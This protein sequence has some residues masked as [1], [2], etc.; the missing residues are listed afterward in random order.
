M[1]NLSIC[2]IN[3]RACLVT[4]AGTRIPEIMKTQVCLSCQELQATVSSEA[5]YVASVAFLKTNGM[6]RPQETGITWTLDEQYGFIM[7]FET[8]SPYTSIVREMTAT[9]F[10]CETP[11]VFC[12]LKNFTQPSICTMVSR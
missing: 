12:G 1:E 3:C 6:W 7:F 10:S 8:W 9:P 4:A 5:K 2:R 11:A